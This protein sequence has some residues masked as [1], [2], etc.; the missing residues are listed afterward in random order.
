E[1]GE[2][3]ALCHKWMKDKI[4]YID[5]ENKTRKI[6]NIEWKIRKKQFVSNA[7]KNYFRSHF[8]DANTLLS[9]WLRNDKKCDNKSHARAYTKQWRIIRKFLEVDYIDDLPNTAPYIVLK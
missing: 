7:E 1:R 8:K 4:L 6:K 2:T 9:I 3:E 5:D